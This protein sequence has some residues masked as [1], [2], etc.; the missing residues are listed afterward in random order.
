MVEVQAPTLGI[1]WLSGPSGRVPVLIS[2]L[3]LWW[4][5]AVPC[6]WGC[7]QLNVCGLKGDVTWSWDTGLCASASCKWLSSWI[8][9]PEYGCIDP[10]REVCCLSQVRWWIWC[11]DQCCLGVQWTLPRR[12]RDVRWMC[13][14]RIVTTVMGVR[15]CGDGYFLKLFH[16]AISY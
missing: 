15:C 6:W 11:V 4:H 8:H 13:R 1:H 2:C 16:V 5:T 9:H 14:P 12:I 7:V 3:Q 10:G